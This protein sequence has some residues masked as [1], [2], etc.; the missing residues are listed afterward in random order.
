MFLAGMSARG[1][2]TIFPL[3]FFFLVFPGT[4]ILCLMIDS[5]TGILGHYA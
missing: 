1:H 5:T 3:I 4:I 2:F